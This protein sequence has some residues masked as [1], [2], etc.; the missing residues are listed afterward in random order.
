MSTSGAP[1]ISVGEATT[2]Q[3]RK[4]ARPQELLDAALELFVQKGYAATRTEEVAA[5][6]GVSKGTLYRYYPSKE[7]LL[8][9]VLRHRLSSQVELGVLETEAHAGSASELLRDS[10]APWWLRVVESPASGVIKLVVTEARSFP[11][12]AECYRLEVVEPG[13]R[14]IARILRR[15]I[16]AGEFRP[17]DVDAAVNSLLLPLMMLCV[18]RHSL[19]ACAPQAAVNARS[20]IKQHVD[21]FVRGLRAS[22]GDAVATPTAD[23][24]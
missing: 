13:R 12:I 22:A 23:R 14:L 17:L 9:A 19:G 4:D 7:E 10:V 16:A 24:L 5:R 21:L 6:A 3:R 8:E 15:G 2:R 1:T 18:H 20:F 11:E